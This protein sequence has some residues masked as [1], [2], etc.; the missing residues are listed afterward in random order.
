MMIVDQIPLIVPV[1]RVKKISLNLNIYRNLHYQVSNKIKKRV[2]SIIRQ[3][4]QMEGVIES[5]PVELIYTI[6]RQNKRREDLMNIGAI[7]DKFVSDALVK[8]GFIPD[9]NIDY[10]KKVS[11]VDGGID[12]V[13]PHA[14]LEIREL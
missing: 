2:V 5:F 10:I 13:N 6:F 11:F 1:S 9:D 14:R 3:N 8:L 12:K 4:C 7:I